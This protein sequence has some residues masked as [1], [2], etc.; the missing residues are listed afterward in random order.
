MFRKSTLI[1]CSL[2]SS[3]FVRSALA[4]DPAPTPTLLKNLNT[5]PDVFSVGKPA[6]SLIFFDLATADSGNELW[7]SDGTVAGTKMVK[8]INPGPKSSYPFYITPISGGTSASLIYFIA[9]DGI[10]GYEL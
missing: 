8:D 9:N 7:V 10:H 2:I 6:G 5:M 1:L 3:L 4:V